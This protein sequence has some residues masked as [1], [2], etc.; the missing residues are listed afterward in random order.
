MSFLCPYFY[1]GQS[2]GGGIIAYID[3]SGL[4]GIIAAPWD[5]STGIQW[6]NGTA[7]ST[8]ATAT[9]LGTGNA[10]TNTIVTVQGAGSYAA[11]L[12]QSLTLGGYSDWYLPSKLEL[13]ELYINRVAIGGFTTNYYWSS[14]QSSIS[15]AWLSN[16]STGAMI[17]NTVGTPERVRA[18]RS[19]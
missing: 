7:V 2:Y 15:W 5:Q 12:C 17:T 11:S 4:H 3:G 16:F 6:Y 13:N 9:A 14:S 10:N 19:F 18:I 8:G 1:I